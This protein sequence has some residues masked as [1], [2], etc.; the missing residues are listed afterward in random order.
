MMTSRDF[1]LIGSSLV[2]AIVI[3][4]LVT[5]AVIKLAHKLGVIDTPKDD[6]RMHS[7]PIPL[8][9]GLSIIIAFFVTT[10]AL[11]FAIR[12]LNANSLPL[13]Y[14]RQ[15]LPGALI[16]ALMGFFDD[17]YTLPALPRLLI[18]CLAAGITVAMG[19]QITK[20]SGSVTLFKTQIF[21][22]SYLSIP[23]TVL[24]IVGMT[25][26]V[27]W[28]DGLDGLASGISSIA[29]FSILLISI[30]QPAEQHLSIAI[31]A[32]AL[33]GGCLG[34][35][36]FNRNPAKVFMGDTGSM[37]LGFTLSVISI[38]GYI[39]IYTTVS[40]LVPLMILGLP[41]LDTGS[42]IIRR[43]LKGV[44]P[45]TA[46]RSHIHHKLVDLGL[47]Q[48]Q[49]VILLYSASGA[50]S[51]V[52]VLF[53]I[54]STTVGWHFLLLGL[55]VV[56]AIF[57]ALLKVFRLKNA[58]IAADAAATSIDSPSAAGMPLCAEQKKPE[59]PGH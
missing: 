34:F 16:I 28:I 2:I 5:P 39:K 23:I 38:Q 25:N 27:N 17:K 30:F 10:I 49:A 1:L 32:A 24:W 7:H 13:L 56:I 43:I 9:G 54:Y 52:G 3:S 11:S 48:K 44:S 40:F 8:M 37:F 19:V 46:D 41:L 59:N 51:I 6:R 53:S 47:S 29:A 50:L 31:L 45:T 58:K 14:I 57:F 15:L 55:A 36:H 21:D 26:A 12:Y 18:Q 33:C 4:V 22:L 42:A 35:L 20:F